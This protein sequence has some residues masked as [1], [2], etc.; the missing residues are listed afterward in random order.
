M[1]PIHW[2]TDHEG[3]VGL[4]FAG[5]GHGLLELGQDGLDAEASWSRRS[6]GDGSEEIR[7]A[8]QDHHVGLGPDLAQ[9]LGQDLNVTAW[10][11]LRRLH[12]RIRTTIDLV[13]M[14]SDIRVSEHGKAPEHLEEAHHEVQVQ[15]VNFL[16]MFRFVSLSSVTNVLKSIW[17][18]L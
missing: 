6:I 5:L 8:G 10:D 16:K 12:Q 1:G 2:R 9:G 15:N 3:D 14:P 17:I 7:D 4:L 13:E 18:F 11:Q